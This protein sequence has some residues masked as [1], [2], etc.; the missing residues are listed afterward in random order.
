MSTPNPISTRGP[1]PPLSSDSPPR[2]IPWKRLLWGRWDWKR[3]IKSLAFIWVALCLVA[4]GFSNKLIFHPPPPQYT[5]SARHLHILKDA[6]NR[7]VAALWYPERTPGSPVLLWSHGNAEDIGALTPLFTELQA[8]GFAILA[9]DYPGYGLSTGSPDEAGCYAAAEA[10]YT[11]L[12]DH[13]Q[14]PSDDIVLFGQSVGSGPACWLAERHEAQAL[15]LVAPFRSAYLTVTRVPL[16]PGD[17][18][19]NIKRIDHIDAPLLV[20]HGVDD[21]II[22]FTDGRAV[23]DR[24]PGPKRFVP[25]PGAHHNNI[26]NR[27]LDTIIAELRNLPTHPTRD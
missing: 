5:D 23:F 14:I 18:F 11:Y 4:C 27:G 26:W 9:Y 12:N 22:P 13:L 1:T 6:N 19:K 15:V 24:H 17:K 20:I 7:D 8:E 3:P 21:R 2:S 25:I 10:A 16:F